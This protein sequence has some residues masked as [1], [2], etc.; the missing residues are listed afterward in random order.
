G[1]E[2]I[3][4]VSEHLQLDGF[5]KVKANAFLK[6]VADDQEVEINLL[7]PRS[8]STLGVR[9]TVVDGL[10]HVDTLSELTFVLSVSP[11]TLEVHAELLDGTTLSYRVLVPTVEMATILKAHSW[12]NRRSENDLAD[13]STLLEIREE[14]PALPW[15]LHER[16][17]RGR[18]LD[19]ARLLRDLSRKITRRTFSGP[20]PRH[21]DRYRFA[22]FIAKHIGTPRRPWGLPPVGVPPSCCVCPARR[23]RSGRCSSSSPSR[24]AAGSGRCTCWAWPCWWWAWA[25]S[26]CAAASSGPG[27]NG[28][29]C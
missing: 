23:W 29:R 6:T 1:V 7:L 16:A 17:L 21:E 4:Q 24:S 18:R 12:H 19:T 3:G 9:A 2:V 15:L 27:R 28:G 5:R 14:H 22:A 13:L 25:D 11:V 26:S 8:D 10:G 20:V